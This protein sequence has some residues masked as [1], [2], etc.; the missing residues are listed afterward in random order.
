[1]MPG[2]KMARRPKPTLRTLIVLEDFDLRFDVAGPIVLPKQLGDALRLKECHHTDKFV[3]HRPRG[4]PFPVA[5][6]SR[7]IGKS[8]CCHTASGSNDRLGLAPFDIDK[9]DVCLQLQ[10]LMKAMIFLC[11]CGFT[12]EGFKGYP[13]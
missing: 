7:P 5:E 12:Q 8:Q 6:E 10:C 9:P 1:M 11:L 2:R 3:Q 4:E 13:A